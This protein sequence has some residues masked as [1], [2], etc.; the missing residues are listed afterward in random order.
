MKKIIGIVAIVATLATSVFAD[1]VT[2]GAWGRGLWS[3]VGS[4][5]KNTV[6]GQG[7]SWAATGTPRVG[8][9]VAGSTENVGFQVDIT[10]ENAGT[11]DNQFIWVKP[12]S[13]LKVEIGKM[14]DDTLRGNACFGTF[15]WLRMGF[16]WKGEDATFSRLGTSDGS[17]S[18]SQL[19]G[20]IVMLDPIEGL[21]I[22]AGFDVADSAVKAEDVYKHSATYQAGYTIKDIG[23]VKAQLIAKPQGTDKDSKAVD[24]SIINAAFD[25]VAVKNLFVSVGAFIPTATV[26]NG[27]TAQVSPTTINLYGRYGMS[28]LTL[29]VLASIKSTKLLDG[30]DETSKMAYAFG[31][32]ANYDL[33][34]GL[35]I[36]A[37]V[38]YEDKIYR[39]NADSGKDDI[40]FLAGVE[41][42]FSNGKIGLGFQ[43]GTNG[44]GPYTSSDTEADA[45]T[46][47]IPV[48][49]EYWF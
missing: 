40:T 27:G 39:N 41:K 3:P 24:F 33:G 32:G 26:Y 4:D 37:D 21:H 14:S 34:N 15:D 28:A 38:R 11:G 35:G 8:F 12:F 31:A 22:A 7:I 36:V 10:G 19:S 25:L 48:K 18:G 23:T 42:G 1:G 9:T 29:H 46:W 49:V 13:M 30:A 17:F 45:F 16:G 44:I 47:A 6:T 43:G 2:V 5:G 20:A